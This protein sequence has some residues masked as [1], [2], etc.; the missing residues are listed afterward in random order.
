MYSV[1]MG[2]YSTV[3]SHPGRGANG[4]PYP[5]VAGNSSARVQAPAPRH[6]VS[7]GTQAPPATASA[8]LQKAPGRPATSEELCYGSGGSSMVPKIVDWLGSPAE[9]RAR[10][11]QPNR[12]RDAARH[13][14]APEAPRPETQLLTRLAAIDHSADEPAAEGGVAQNS[15]S[16]GPCSPSSDGLAGAPHGAEPAT[17]EPEAEQ[18]PRSHGA[19][20]S[21]AIV[22]EDISAGS[23]EHPT[24]HM[25]ALFGYN[26]TSAE[27]ESSIRWSFASTGRSHSQSEAASASQVAGYSTDLTLGS[28]PLSPAGKAASPV[29]SCIGSPAAGS[30]DDARGS[31]SERSE[32]SPPPSVAASVD[33]A[34]GDRATAGD[35]AET[36]LGRSA[37]VASPLDGDQEPAAPGPAVAGSFAMRVS[38]RPP[39]GGLL[40][41]ARP[42]VAIQPA[43]PTPEAIAAR[44]ADVVA[45]AGTLLD[46]APADRLPFEDLIS[47]EGSPEPEGFS[48][49]IAEGLLAGSGEDE[50]EDPVE[51]VE[52]PCAEPA[53]A[54]G[55]CARPKRTAGGDP[56][57]VRI[58]LI[59]KPHVST[60]L[61][62]RHE[63]Y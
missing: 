9:T 59:C 41:G 53:A 52:G 46:T 12:A 26:E 32:P 39:V 58:F 22:T 28:P 30:G 43:S 3:S 54:V 55:P 1:G 49:G 47:P 33:V 23:L 56:M 61:A 29:P 13:A 21:D 16:P 2:E 37:A 36:R 6:T 24:D 25:A 11:A 42:C 31:G 19:V 18:H 40:D 44:L 60:Y 7:P 14:M 17:A 5:T 38:T 35:Y 4:T 34:D 8:G 48:E 27:E 20:D 50:D 62:A 45:A 51:G 15:R 63:P 57:D 10:Q